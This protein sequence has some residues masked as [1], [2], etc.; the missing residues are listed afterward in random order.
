MSERDVAAA[1]VWTP[2][3]ELV[4]RQ[5]SWLD[6]RDKLMLWSPKTGEARVVVQRPAEEWGIHYDSPLGTLE[7]N[8]KRLALVYARPGSRLGLAR[9]R[10]LWAVD[11]RTGSRRLLYPDIWTDE[12]LWRDGRIYLKER[13]NLWSL[14]PDGGRLRRESYLPPPEGVR[15]P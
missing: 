7:P 6:R 14:S 1:L 10:E 15:S 3:G 12:L 13:N 5:L 4:F 2:A 8:G 9:N 11:L